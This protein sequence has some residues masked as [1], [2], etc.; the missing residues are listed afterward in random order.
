M[1]EFLLELLSEEIPARMQARAAADLHRLVT[2]ALTAAGLQFDRAEAHVTP[3]RLALAVDGL[4]SRQPDQREERKGPK[5][6]APEAAIAGFLKST[7]LTLDQCERRDTPKGPVWFAVF[8]KPGRPTPEV[9]AD[10]LRDT[11]PALPWP[12]SMRWAESGFRWVRPLH[13]VLA[14]FDGAP[15]PGDW[16]PDPHQRFVFSALTSGHR[17]LAPGDFAVTGFADYRAKLRAAKVMLDRDER[18]ALILQQAG[19]LATAEGLRLKDD[20]GLVE[21]VAGL[22]EWPVALLGR[23]DEEFM[24]VP[25]EVLTTAMRTH[26]RYFACE[27]ADGALAPRFV[28]IANTETRDGGA[29]VVAGNEKVLRAR[30]SDARFFWDQDRKLPL[31]DRV[32]ALKAITFHA[33]LGTVFARAERLRGLAEAVAGMISDR[34]GQPAATLMEQAARAAHLAKADLV[35]GM[36]GEFPELQGLMGR[37]YAA[38]QGE[39]E[40]VA[41]AIGEHYSPLGP[42]DRCPSAPVSIAV[43]L[44][45]KID[46][47]VGF[48]AIDEKPTGS[49]DPYALRRAALGVLRL[50]LE[51]DLDLDLSDPCRSAIAAYQVQG[52]SV[53]EDGVLADLG[54]FLAERLKGMLRDRGYRHDHIDAAFAAAGVWRPLDLQRRVEALRTLLDGADGANLL[55]GYR[56]AASIVRIEEKK[57][58]RRYDEPVDPALLAEPAERALAEAL[59]GARTALAGRLAREDYPGAMAVLAALRPAID[60]YFDTVTVNADDPALRGNRLAQLTAIVETMNHVAEF[61][62]VEG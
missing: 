36:V 21:E 37:Y 22:V 57:D 13:R 33:K 8:E 27:T 30:L 29:S 49:R 54:G 48:W 53:D 25:P 4:P 26:Q 24:T 60:G 32:P 40:A 10:I 9:L 39:T 38:Q 12:K 58:G 18:K 47:L 6:D 62:R 56:R 15:L 41:Q 11:L 5:T 51:N 17:F 3:R 19:A 43:A 1:A 52:L 59:D 14:L 50:A 2:E 42:T 31:Q 44:A 35:T 7:G 23:I 28:V 61:A 20:P 55:A 46:T 34:V 45:D 16:E